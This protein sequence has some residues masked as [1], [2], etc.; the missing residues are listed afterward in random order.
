MQIPLIAVDIGNSRIK[1]GRLDSSSQSGDLPEPSP[2]MAITASDWN[3][4]A[5]RQWLD[6]ISAKYEIWI[7][8]VNRP[9]TERFTNWLAK[10][11]S[12]SPVR[13]ITHRDLPIEVAL[14]NPERVGIDRLAGAVAANRLRDPKSPA[15]TIHVGTAITVNLISADGVFCGGAIAPGIA[16][17]ARAL[18]QFTDLLPH[19]QIEELI[20]PTPPL[21]KNTLQAIHSGLFWGAVGTMRELIAGLSE[22]LPA[23]PDVFITGGAAPAIVKLVDPAAEYVEHL[24]LSGIALAN[25]AA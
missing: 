14:E 2:V 22:P 11:D 16:I 5:V 13:L 10:N 7:A 18:D 3:E 17:S 21:G 24:V 15:I 12:K 6:D 4:S 23:K 19:M 9:A 8:S 25:P 20:E 1:L